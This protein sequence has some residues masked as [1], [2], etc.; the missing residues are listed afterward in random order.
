[1]ASWAEESTP[2]TKRMLEQTLDIAEKLIQEGR[3][4]DGLSLVRRVNDVIQRRR[5]ELRSR[6]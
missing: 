2:T 3:V 5:K 4:E 6:P 1:M